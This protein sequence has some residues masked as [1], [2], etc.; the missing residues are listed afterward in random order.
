[1][2]TV[3]RNG[4]TD[5]LPYVSPNGYIDGA[6]YLYVA[7]AEG[8]LDIVKHLLKKGMYSWNHCKH[9]VQKGQTPF[10]AA[11]VGRHDK[12]LQLLEPIPEQREE[13]YKTAQYWSNYYMQKHVGEL[14]LQVH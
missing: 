10:Y 13:Y 2:Y 7:C 5:V 9:C 3:I 11:M 12:I 6:S 8:Q 1:M 4:Y 14:T